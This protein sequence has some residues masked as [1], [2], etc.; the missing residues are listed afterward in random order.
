M[1]LQ[2]SNFAEAVGLLTAHGSDDE[3]ELSEDKIIGDF[4]TEGGESV[5]LSSEMLFRVPAKTLHL[6]SIGLRHQPT[7]LNLICQSL[8]SQLVHPVN[9]NL[10]KHPCTGQHPYETDKPVC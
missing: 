4:V 7:A 5:V 10:L 9:L 2:K 3:E 8:G 6:C 1:A